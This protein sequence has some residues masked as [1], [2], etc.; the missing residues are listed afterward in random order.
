MEGAT[1]KMRGGSLVLL[2]GCLHGGMTAAAWASDERPWSAT[3]AG[4]QEPGEPL[5]VTG[6][7][8]Q[9]DGVIPA[10]GVQVYVY[11]ADQN[12][13]YSEQATNSSNPRLKATVWTDAAGRYALRTIRPGSYPD[14]RVP[15]HVHFVLTPEGGAEQR[16]ELRFAGDPFLSPAAVERS[17]REGGFGEIQPLTRSADGVWHAVRDL[18]LAQ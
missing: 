1:F 5:E 15:A 3:L 13:Y 18:R 4:P 10:V 16:F 9:A 17:A 7:V 11:H 8:Y 14:A 2:I 12:G 6:T